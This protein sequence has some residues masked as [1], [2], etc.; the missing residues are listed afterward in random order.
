MFK[1]GFTLIETLVVVAILSIIII[2]LTILIK[3]AII[4]GNEGYVNFEVIS[5]ELSFITSL[6]KTFANEDSMVY[7]IDDEDCTL[8]NERV[9]IKLLINSNCKIN[10][11]EYKVIF[12]G[13]EINKNFIVLSFD[14]NDRLVKMIFRSRLYEIRDG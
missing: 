6:E 13:I 5:N 14:I 4:M 3:K 10:E 7:L 2:P 8:I 12:K 9:E 11:I 1:N